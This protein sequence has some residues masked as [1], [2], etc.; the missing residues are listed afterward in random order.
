LNLEPETLNSSHSPT[1]NFQLSNSNS[2]VHNLHNVCTPQIAATQGQPCTCAPPPSP[3]KKRKPS[4]ITRE[5]AAPAEPPYRPAPHEREH[6]HINHKP[7]RTSRR[8]AMAPK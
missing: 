1:E 7:K 2:T 5:G 3:K 6:G 4:R 8:L